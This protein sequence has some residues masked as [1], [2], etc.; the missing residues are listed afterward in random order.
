MQTECKCERRDVLYRSQVIII[1]MHSLYFY[2]NSIQKSY[3]YRSVSIKII[4]VRVNKI[5]ECLQW[6]C[7]S[8]AGAQIQQYA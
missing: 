8:P 1:S 7:N 5:N 2:E 3:F 4:I 6:I